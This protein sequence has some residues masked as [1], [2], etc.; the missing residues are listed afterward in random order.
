MLTLNATVH[1]WVSAQELQRKEL[2][3]DSTIDAQ[4][5]QLDRDKN[6]VKCTDQKCGACYDCLN[7]LREDCTINRDLKDG[8]SML[9]GTWDE[10]EVR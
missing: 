3:D 10:A 2:L 5:E 9:Y 8:I 4:M 6:F 7:E 1:N